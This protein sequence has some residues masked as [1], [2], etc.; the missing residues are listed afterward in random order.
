MCWWAE[1][2]KQQAHYQ[3]KLEQNLNFGNL[4]I[5]TLSDFKEFRN[6]NFNFKPCFE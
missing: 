6:F 2:N 1:K 4:E 3:I 5:K